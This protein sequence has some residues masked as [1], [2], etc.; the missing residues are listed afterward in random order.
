MNEEQKKVVAELRAKPEYSPAAYASNKLETMVC[1]GG[2]SIVLLLAL[3]L[4][5]GLVIELASSLLF[6]KTNVAN[7]QD[8]VEVPVWVNVFL[9][10]VWTLAVFSF[11]N[12]FIAKKCSTHLESRDAWF[13]EELKN[14]GIDPLTVSPESFL[15]YKNPEPTPPP[16]APV[17]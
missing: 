4:F 10:I 15:E 16:T 14:A 1:Y 7:V 5:G 17:A 2:A 12:T 9:T 8:I 13:N 3:S 11:G 6:T